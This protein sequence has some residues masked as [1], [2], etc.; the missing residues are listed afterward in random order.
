MLFKDTEKNCFSL[1]FRQVEFFFSCVACWHVILTKEKLYPLTLDPLHIEEE[2]NA[3]GKKF[4]YL[5]YMCND[6]SGCDIF[7]SNI[8]HIKF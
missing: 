3:V 2:E 8:F 7:N 1:T 6:T 4:F 5:V